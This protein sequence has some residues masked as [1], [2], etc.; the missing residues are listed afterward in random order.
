MVTSKFKRIREKTL[1]FGIVRL[2]KADTTKT[3]KSFRQFHPVVFV[4]FF[5]ATNANYKFSKLVRYEPAADLVKY[6]KI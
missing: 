2:L 4:L 6:L 5:L 1:L 3:V